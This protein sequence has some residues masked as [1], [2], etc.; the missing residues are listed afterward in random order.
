M[1]KHPGPWVALSAH[2]PDDDDIIAAG[3]RAAWLYLVMICDIRARRTD[4]T[5]S[6][7][8]VARLNVPGWRARLDKLAAI[9]L[10]R[11]NRT[12]V[13]VPAYLKWNRSEAE[14]EQ[15]SSQ[16]RGAACKRHHPQPCETCAQPAQPTPIRRAE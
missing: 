5:I 14:Y 15:I 3:E 16:R 13:T 12:T 4:G 1:K 8:R 11:I 2:F 10:V 9:G 6:M 7:D